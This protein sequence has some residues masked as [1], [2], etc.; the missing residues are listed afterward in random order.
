MRPIPLGL[1]LGA[2]NTL[3]IALG[4]SAVAGEF[5]VALFV[6]SIGIIPAAALG[7]I[8]GWTAD[9][10]KHHCPWLRRV[11]LLVPAIMLVAALAAQFALQQF[12]LVACIPTIVAGLVLERSTRATA[13]PPPIPVARKL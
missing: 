9:S 4:M 7:G 5:G 6:L 11:I 10:M 3:V 8:L 12:V 2:A 1:V 13:P